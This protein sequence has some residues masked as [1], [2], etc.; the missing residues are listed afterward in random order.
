MGEQT[1]VESRNAGGTDDQREHRRSIDQR[2]VAAKSGSTEAALL[3]GQVGPGVVRLRTD[4]QLTLHR[5]GAVGPV[6]SL[7]AN[8]H[9]T[10][11]SLVVYRNT[12]TR[13]PAAQVSDGD[14]DLCLFLSE[15]HTGFALRDQGGL[16]PGRSLQFF[17]AEG[18]AVHKIFLRES[19]DVDA[20]DELVRRQASDHQIPAPERQAESG[21]P[22]SDPTVPTTESDPEPHSDI[23]HLDE[24]LPLVHSSDLTQDHRFAGP[25]WSQ[26][27]ARAS[28]RQVLETA[29]VSKVP[30]LI[31][32]GN[33]GA[34]QN[35]AGP[36][37][38]LR[39]VDGW[40]AIHD[41]NFNLHIDELG[42]ESAWVVRK[43]TPDGVVTSLELYDR[44]GE[45]IVYLARL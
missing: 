20:F 21:E 3:G 28:L 17:D 23:R 42:I 8:R 19:S 2:E 38:G 36:V 34:I 4:W 24:S 9:A 10:I 11:G 25:M 13:G 6:I 1:T 39:E 29:I 18:G 12:A 22:R 16:G 31:M 40:L 15:W 43:A 41:S 32:V 5:L 35:H 37:G 27:V 33:H 30:L 45:M 7:T 44:A 14:T 26:R